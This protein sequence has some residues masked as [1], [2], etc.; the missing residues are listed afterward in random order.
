MRGIGI[1]LARSG[2]D[3]LHENEKLALE[4]SSRD[5]LRKWWKTLWSLHIPPEFKILA[6]RRVYH[7]I[8]FWYSKICR[9]QVP[10]TPNCGGWLFMQEILMHTFFGC[11]MVRDF[12]KYANFG[13]VLRSLMESGADMLLSLF[14]RLPK[15]PFEITC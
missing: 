7:N 15:E 1:L 9:H 12:W 2:Y 10:F 8:L 5:P 11:H 4:R 14:W 13:K 6:W 3:L